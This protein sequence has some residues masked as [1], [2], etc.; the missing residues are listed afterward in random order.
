[1][2][3]VRISETAEKELDSI[4]A[5]LRIYFKKHIEKVRDMP[6]RRHLRYGLPFN[7]VN[8]TKQARLVYQTEDNQLFILRCF[9]T[10]KEYERWYRSFK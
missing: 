5:Q 8:V 3:E 10:H 7:V 6:P 2:A 4:D 1:M 9:A